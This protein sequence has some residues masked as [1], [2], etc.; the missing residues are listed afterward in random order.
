MHHRATALG[1]ILACGLLLGGL[2]AEGARAE[3]LP[4]RD[5]LWETTTHNPMTGER[6]SRECLKDTVLD[7]QT[8]L[9]G[10]DDCRMTEQARDGNT[11]TFTMACAG[12]SGTAEGH[13]FVEGDQG[14]G[15]INMHFDMGG[16]LM[17]MTMSWDAVRVGDC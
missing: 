4:I 2:G 6:T 15:E 8:M 13:M 3:G 12:G 5:G 9:E 11:L 1:V 16:R 10:Q 7:P 14:G 17:D